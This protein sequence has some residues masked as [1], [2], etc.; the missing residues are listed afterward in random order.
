MTTTGTVR[1]ATGERHALRVGDDAVRARTG[2]TWAQWFAAL[3]RAGADRLE[4]AGIARLLAGRFGCPP[5]W[6]QMVTVAYEQARGR[7]VRHQTATGFTVSGSR[8]VDVPLRTLYAAWQDAGQRSRWLPGGKL[9]VR[10]ATAGKSLR[11][12]WD[13]GPTR[14]EVR[15]LAKGRGRAQV[16]VEHGRLPDA[17]AAARMKAFWKTRLD[18]LQAML[19]AGA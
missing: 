6:A 4:H 12:S 9:A 7:R 8:I 18:R 14:L 15:F 19:E 2:R 10:S 17:R 11:A 3:D 13:G 5:W 1:R 16:A